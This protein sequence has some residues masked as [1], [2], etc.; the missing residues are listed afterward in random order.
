MEVMARQREV[1]R[2]EIARVYQ[3]DLSVITDVFYRDETALGLSFSLDFGT[4]PP[5]QQPKFTELSLK[6]EFNCLDEV[7]APLIKSM[8]PCNLSPNWIKARANQKDETIAY[9]RE[10]QNHF[11]QHPKDWI[12]ERGSGMTGMGIDTNKAS[13]RLQVV[14]ARDQ[15]W[16]DW[17]IKID[18]KAKAERGM[19]SFWGQRNVAT[20]VPFPS[21]LPIQQEDGKEV[22]GMWGVGWT[23]DCKKMSSWLTTNDV[24]GRW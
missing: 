7:K 20:A 17:N 8:F 5:E 4:L 16:D 9:P 2:L 15:T 10:F 1:V 23:T 22:R 11:G 21:P 14:V 19:F 24:K 13:W 12:A 3:Q 18:V 6:V